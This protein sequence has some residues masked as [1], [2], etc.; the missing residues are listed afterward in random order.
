MGLNRR[1]S[2]KVGMNPYPSILSQKY[3]SSSFDLQGSL[4]FAI[5]NANECVGECERT[6]KG[7]SNPCCEGVGV[8]INHAQRWA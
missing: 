8:L 3:C 6:Q 2:K 4:V 1:L 5:Y 7:L